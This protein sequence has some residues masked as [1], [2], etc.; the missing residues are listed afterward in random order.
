MV[1]EKCGYYNDDDAP[2]CYKCGNRLQSDAHDGGGAAAPAPGPAGTHISGEVAGK[3]KEFGPFRVI[4]TIALCLFSFFLVFS[5][6][7]NPEGGPLSIGAGGIILAGIFLAFIGIPTWFNLALTYLI[8]R[9]FRTGTRV[10]FVVCVAVS[11]AISLNFRL[12][13]MMSD[14]FFHFGWG[15]QVS[16]HRKM[17]IT[18]KE[19]VTVIL[20][21]ISEIEYRTNPLSTFGIDLDFENFG[22]GI[23]RPMLEKTTVESLQTHLA[24]RGIL[25]Q[26]NDSSERKIVI[27]GKDN[28]FTVE[29]TV[30]VL[31]GTEETA[32]YKNRFRKFYYQEDQGGLLLYK[33]A[34]SPVESRTKFL[35]A[36]FQNTFWNR[37]LQACFY[38][39]HRPSLTEFIDQAL[40]IKE[41]PAPRERTLAATVSK[42]DKLEETFSA[43]EHE[44]GYESRFAAIAGTCRC[45]AA[46]TEV[47]MV[48]PD[49]H[50]LLFVSKDGERKV[51][52]YRAFPDTAKAFKEFRVTPMKVICLDTEVIVIEEI[53]R[54]FRP[55]DGGYGLISYSPEGDL[56][57]AY[58]LDMPAIQ[59]RKSSPK[60]VVDFEKRAGSY[61]FTLVD[62]DENWR[63]QNLY[64]VSVKRNDRD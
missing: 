9:W 35:L 20:D 10:T 21:N 43:K 22:P 48:F 52:P 33:K 46:S 5:C 36:I 1:C 23:A 19:P 17:T 12:P 44:S 28:G 40:E 18:P 54:S 2:L 47:K 4:C 15:K 29:V 31:A 57:D 16:I 24:D 3:K 38:T 25:V 58:I 14:I 11:L 27:K 59:W 7:S 61:D 45:G 13:G 50:Y 51:F 55:A 62:I 53:E 8:V 6:F 26:R 63:I 56:L 32:R 49:A 39:Y 64:R 42:T 60:P 41:D 34:Y 37:L 30:S